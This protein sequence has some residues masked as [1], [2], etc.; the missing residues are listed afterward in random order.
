MFQPKWKWFPPQN[1]SHRASAIR[2]SRST[3]AWTHDL[4]PWLLVWAG[5]LKV[6]RISA[7][8][9]AYRKTPEGVEVFLVHP[10]GPLWA[11][12]DQGAWSIPKGECAA[13]E[14]PLA[15]ALR[16]FHEE[17]GQT[18]DGPFR[19]L[20]PQRLRSGKIVHAFACQADLDPA[21]VVSNP[22][23]LEWPPRSGRIQHFPEVDRAEWFSLEEACLRLNPGQVG[24]LTELLELLGPAQ[25]S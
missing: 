2:L 12:K 15:A 20:K 22:F 4:S 25:E 10:G 11:R 6:A 3:F 18:L 21:L 7:G 9:L 8:I 24:F 17:V 19:A 5:Q 1:D 23:A 14:E 13:D 16:E